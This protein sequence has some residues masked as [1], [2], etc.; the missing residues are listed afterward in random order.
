MFL[1]HSHHSPPSQMNIQSVIMNGDRSE[2]VDRILGRMANIRD[3]TDGLYDIDVN[4]TRAQVR[5]GKIGGERERERERK[6]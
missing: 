6:G 5:E 4:Y 3:N 2:M 1:P